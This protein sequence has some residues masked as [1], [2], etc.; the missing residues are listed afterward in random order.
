M[1]E[2]EIFKEKGGGGNRD[3]NLK[4]PLRVLRTSGAFRLHFENCCPCFRL[5]P[6]WGCAVRNKRKKMVLASWWSQQQKPPKVNVEEEEDLWIFP[7]VLAFRVRSCPSADESC[8]WIHCPCDCPG[9][10]GH[11]SLEKKAPRWEARGR[12]RGGHRLSLLQLHKLSFLH[13]PLQAPCGNG[14]GLTLWSQKDLEHLSRH[15]GNTH[16]DNAC[17]ENGLFHRWCEAWHQERSS[18]PVQV[19]CPPR[20]WVREDRVILICLFPN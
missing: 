9:W 3:I 17:K 15:T 12:V 11:P 6:E 2:A 7:P 18:P 13:L 14:M 8:P 1:W 19:N 16:R 20:S 4:D 5:L 10:S